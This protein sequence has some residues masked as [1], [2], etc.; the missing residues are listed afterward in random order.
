MKA[1]LS[2]KIK[3]LAR[4]L[5]FQKVGIT[6]ATG[7]PAEGRNL[8]TWL[9]RGNHGEMHWIKNRLTERV[10]IRKYFPGARS[11]I[12]LG[13][14]YFTGTSDDRVTADFNLSN[15]AWGDDYH[16]I[17]KERLRRLYASIRQEAGEAV[18]GIV[19]VD[20]SPVLEK[21][22]AQ[23]AG[24]G[25]QGKH[26]NLITRDY[27]SWLFLGEVILNL[28]LDYDPPF[29]EDLCG[30]CQACVEACP[31]GA[32]SDYQ[33]DSRKCISYLTIEHRGEFLP[34]QEQGLND[35]VY[36]CDICQ[37]VCPWNIKFQ[38]PSPE[39]GFRSRNELTTR[40]LEEWQSDDQ[41]DF[42]RIFRKSAVKR[43]KFS[44]WQRNLAAVKTNRH[45]Q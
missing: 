39:A 8:Q 17:V 16:L 12:S 5:G 42:S 6:A 22:W 33:L 30:T 19:C 13:M 29:S 24:L 36:G 1:S 31:T 28:K 3:A 27:G 32:L 4:E 14:N 9:D 11:I 26:T 25:W 21:V 15:Y 23:R 18:K 44:G 10:D 20:T 41:N 43:T 37:Q 2:D 35:W 7:L 40:T 45:D 38:Q 34:E